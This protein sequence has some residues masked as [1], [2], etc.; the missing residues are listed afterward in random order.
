MAMDSKPESE[1]NE[2]LD[3]IFNEVVPAIFPKLET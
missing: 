2:K 3:K 1:I